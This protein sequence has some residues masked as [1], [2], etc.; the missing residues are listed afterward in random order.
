MMKR[1]RAPTPN[2]I[3]LA[4]GNPGRRPINQNE[5]KPP[6]ARPEPPAHL[7]ATAKAEWQRVVGQLFDCGLMTALDTPMLMAYCDA[8]GRYV[9]ASRTME[10]LAR[11]DPVTRGVLVRTAN[12]NPIMNPVLCTLRS[13]RGDMARFA[14]EFGMSPASRSRINVGIPPGG[15]GRTS[16]ARDPEDRFF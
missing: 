6:P 16:G 15:D 7:G 14:V 8:F 12:G 11:A 13:S 9:E 4:A 1:G 5:P 2:V 3:R 10:E